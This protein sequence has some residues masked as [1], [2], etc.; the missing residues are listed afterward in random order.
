[1]SIHIGQILLD[2][3]RRNYFRP[4]DLCTGLGIKASSLYKIF[5]GANTSTRMLLKMSLLMKHD[6]FQYYQELI[7][8]YSLYKK[9][10]ELEKEKEV[11]QRENDLMKKIFNVPRT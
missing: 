9:I 6:F 11:L 8:G 4:I 2:Y 10:E 7:T 3:S 5:K 1:M